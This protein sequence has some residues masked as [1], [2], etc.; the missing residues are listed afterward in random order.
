[1]ANEAGIQYLGDY[2]FSG[3]CLGRTSIDTVAFFG[4]TPSTRPSGT[5]QAA[6]TVTAGTTSTSALVASVQSLATANKTLLNEIRSALV[7]RLGL[8]AGA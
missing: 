4:G 5:S 8:I 1:M 6:V 2:G 3:T 7:D